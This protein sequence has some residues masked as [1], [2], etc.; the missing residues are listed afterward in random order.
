MTVTEIDRWLSSFLDIG[1]LEGIDSSQNGL[2]VGAAAGEVRKVAFAVDASME[3]FRRAAQWGAQMLV[4]HHGIIWAAPRADRRLRCSNGCGSWR[5]RISRCTR[6]ISRWTVTPRWA[7]TS[8]SPSTSASRTSPRSG[9]STGSPSAAGARCPSRRPWKQVVTRLSGRQGEQVRTLPF[10]SRLVRTGRDHLGLRPP[11]MSRRP[12][13][14]DWTCSSRGS[15]RTRSIIIASSAN[16]CYLCW[17]LPLGILR[18]PVARRQARAGNGCGN[19]ISRHPHGVMNGP[20]YEEKR[21]QVPAR[22][23]HPLRGDHHRRPGD[24]DH[25]GPHHPQGRR[26]PCHR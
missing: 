14:R 15:R 5:R 10:G 6:P 20:E 17:S 12:S 2:Q 4:V 3:S 11:R 18:C 21:R 13:R 23:P 16:P 26:G 22:H 25:R 1:A 9:R 7:T 19:D 24:E 8:A